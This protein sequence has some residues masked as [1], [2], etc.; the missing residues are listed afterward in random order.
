[1]KP[2]NLQKAIEIISAHHSTEIIINKPINNN[3]NVNNLYI[4]NCV[5]SVIDKL[6]DAGFSLS[7]IEGLMH[8]D[9]VFVGK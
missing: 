7:M 6:R 3:A 1:M 9:D 8:V 2:E 5:P 4:K